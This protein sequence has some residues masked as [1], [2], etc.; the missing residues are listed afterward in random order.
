M[1]HELQRS[2][3]R[4]LL[5]PA[6]TV[7]SS[8]VSPLLVTCALLCVEEGA[9]KSENYWFNGIV[10]EGIM[11]TFSIKFRFP[12]KCNIDDMPELAFYKKNQDQVESGRIFS[13]WIKKTKFKNSKPAKECTGTK[14]ALVC[15]CPSPFYNSFECVK[16]FLTYGVLLVSSNPHVT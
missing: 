16:L 9:I 10:Q 14:R 5:V 15:V 7:V 12:C 2:E 3:S 8:A 6:W 4:C 1:P 13:A 11:P